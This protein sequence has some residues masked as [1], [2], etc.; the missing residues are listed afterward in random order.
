MG[1]LKTCPASS[2]RR[3]SALAAC[4]AANSYL[5]SDLLRLNLCWA[6][7]PSKFCKKTD[8]KKPSFFVGDSGWN[9]VD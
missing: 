8:K 7:R 2:G 5:C 3:S 6:V 9:F 1:I 4:L